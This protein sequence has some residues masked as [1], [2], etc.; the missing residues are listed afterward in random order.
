MFFFHR[1]EREWNHFIDM[2]VQPDQ[3]HVRFLNNPVDDGIR[4]MTMDVGQYRHVM[5]YVSQ[6]RD[7]DNENS[8]QDFNNW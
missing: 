5:D 8:H 1:R 6:R 4:I 3:T 7:T 2:F